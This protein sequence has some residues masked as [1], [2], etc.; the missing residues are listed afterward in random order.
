LLSAS[1]RTWRHGIDR[2][3]QSETRELIVEEDGV[4]VM[5][6]LVA[7]LMGLVFGVGAVW[8]QS[9]TPQDSI[10]TR[11]ENLRQF[12]ALTV[13]NRRIASTRIL[14]AFYEQRQFRLAWTDAAAADEL[15]RAIRD[16]EQDGLDPE[17]YHLT[18][19]NR[20]RAKPTLDGQQSFG[21]AITSWSAKWTRNSSI[22][23]GI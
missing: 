17:D 10:R 18:A 9:N 15:L 23:T 13:S 14:P 22:A 4:N 12:G 3:N 19:L 8:A 2:N 20:L 5:K 6:W 21:L 7:S 16:S 1:V 11:I